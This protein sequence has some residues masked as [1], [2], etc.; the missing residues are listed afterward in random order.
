MS[1]ETGGVGRPAETVMNLRPGGVKPL[2]GT[3]RASE[4]KRVMEVEAL[5]NGGELDL[6]R[7]L[8]GQAEEGRTLRERAAGRQAPKASARQSR[9]AGLSPA[10]RLQKLA[11]IKKSATDY[12]AIFIDQLV[13]LMRP[14]ALAHT[15]G[16]ETFSEIAEQP[17]RDFLSRAGGLGLADT[18]VGQIARQEGL[19]QTLQ[20]HPEVMGP[21]W[22]PTIPGNPGPRTYERLTLAPAA[23]APQGLGPNSGPPAAPARPEEARAA[24]IAGPRPAEAG[25]AGRAGRF[26]PIPNRED[27]HGYP[28]DT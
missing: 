8:E 5:K 28:A 11:K 12:E 9:S 22:R 6:G 17:F 21:S 13:K 23:F 26:G 27:K 20:E 4:S 1:Q 18:M 3:A 10:E 2:R 14:S 7:L 19:E 16:G 24:E 25:S 15:P